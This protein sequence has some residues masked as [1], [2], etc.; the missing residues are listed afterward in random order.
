MENI[1]GYER[2][3]LNWFTINK[4]TIWIVYFERT[5]RTQEKTTRTKKMT[6]RTKERTTRTKKRTTRTKERTTRTKERTT[7]TKE[8]TTSV[9]PQFKFNSHAHHCNYEISSR[10]HWC[11]VRMC[12]KMQSEPEIIELLKDVLFLSWSE[13][14]KNQDHEKVG[15]ANFCRQSFPNHFAP[16][17]LLAGNMRA[18]QLAQKWKRKIELRETTQY[19]WM[20]EEKS[21]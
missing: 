14:K 8:R 15:F 6:T 2:Y 19:T 7:R 13:G 4:L 20:C 21:W 18:Q 17:W 11:T 10:L 1:N 16:G 3:L 9:L 5:T 12:T